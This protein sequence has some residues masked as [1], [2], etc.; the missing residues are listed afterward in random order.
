VADLGVGT[1]Q[2]T[3]LLAR[4]A[5]LVIAVDQDPAVIQRL[6][7]PETD[8]GRLVGRVGTIEA[9]PLE[10]GEVDLVLL[11]QS[12]HCVDD[13]AAALVAVH[14]RLAPG[15]RVAV[16]DLAPHEHGWVRTR[17]GHRHLGFADLGGMLVAAGFSEV[18]SEVVHRDR[19]SPAFTTVLATGRVG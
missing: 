1:G 6:S 18:R 3:R 5:A 12:L 9:P 14:A 11:S 19:V 10:R 2:L 7:G 16:V 8:A 17:F 15:G 4:H 13:P